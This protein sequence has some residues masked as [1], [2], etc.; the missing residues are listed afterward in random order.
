MRVTKYLLVSSLL[1][2][3]AVRAEEAEVQE[4][5]EIPG[6]AQALI[7]P[8]GAEALLNR[9][10]RDG[11]GEI[12]ADKIKGFILALNEPLFEKYDDDCDGFIDDTEKMDYYADARK[13]ADEAFAKAV[14]S[15]EERAHGR[16]N[17]N[18]G[19]P[20]SREAA[21]NVMPNPGLKSAGIKGSFSDIRKPTTDGSNYS[22]ELTVEQAPW[23][24]FRNEVVPVT[25]GLD[26]SLGAKRESETTSTSRTREEEVTF[27]PFSVK[28]SDPDE[29]LTLKFSLGAAYVW[30]QETVL[31]TAVTTREALPTFAYASEL[32]YAL[33]PKKCWSV[34]LKYEYKSR[35]MFSGKVA[36]TLKPMLGVKFVCDN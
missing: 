21:L 7:K 18:L 26:W 24:S 22:F 16:I 17:E 19:K 5:V 4:I 3:G 33:G 1:T 20:L 6:V 15:V 14:T 35:Q 34:G 29:R 12:D 36:T 27:T 30:S 9:C 11:S 2:C 28:T 23:R 31:A 10:D 25:L 32:S 8:Q 13:K